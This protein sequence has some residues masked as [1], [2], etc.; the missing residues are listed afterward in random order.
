MSHRSHALAALVAIALVVTVREA[1]AERLFTLTEDGRTFLYRAR[2]GDYPTGVAEMFGIPPDGLAAFLKANGITDAT[3]VETGFVYRIPNAAVQALAARVDTLEASNA[4]LT[5]DL[6]ASQERMRGLDKTAKNARDGLVAAEAR[7]TH[8]ARL[9]TL[10]PF[11]QAVLTLLVL[12]AAALVALAAAALRRR[13]QAE[14]YARALAL[15]LDE[16]RKAA[17]SE[18]Q[19][20]ARRILDLENRV[21]SLEAQLGPRVLVGGRGS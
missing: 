4:R 5:H 8:L 14:R 11:V 7:A 18:R 17:M 3:R 15:E 6:E 12:G 13:T 21:R 10:W 19:E 1:A 16:K 2:P 20:S 9:E